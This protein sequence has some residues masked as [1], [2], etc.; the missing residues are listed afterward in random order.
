MNP[1]L[2]FAFIALLLLSPA[3]G[4]DRGRVRIAQGTVVAESG[5][6]LRGGHI[7]LDTLAAARKV[8][9][10][11]FQAF[12]AAKCNLV[13][14]T[15]DGNGKGSLR[16]ALPVSR[17]LPLFD[18]AVENASRA[19]LYL[20]LEYAR[21]AP[22]TRPDSADLLAFWSTLAPRYAERSH[23]FFGI[24]NEPVAWRASDYTSADIRLQEAA[25]ARIRALAP[26]TL[27]TLFTFAAL[28]DSAL[29]L[30]ARAKGIDYAHAAIDFHTYGIDHDLKKLAAR[31]KALQTRYPVFCGEFTREPA[32]GND[33]APEKTIEALEELGVSWTSLIFDGFAPIDKASHLWGRDAATGLHPVRDPARGGVA[34]GLLLPGMSGMPGRRAGGGTWKI[35][36]SGKSKPAADAVGRRQGTFGPR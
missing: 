34:Y 11:A 2:L 29:A 30:V 21:N 5:E 23:V 17:V 20:K 12:A 9:L 28:D 7:Q 3:Q 27:I 8:S 4:A 10:A 14:L 31:V 25:F 24:V 32:A 26:K 22:G 19:G 33:I 15:Y 36:F 16:P 35:R 13:R 18:S 6:R 1:A